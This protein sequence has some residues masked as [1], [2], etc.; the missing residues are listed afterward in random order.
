VHEKVVDEDGNKTQKVEIYYKF[1]GT[2]V[3]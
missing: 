2:A 1:V 3:E